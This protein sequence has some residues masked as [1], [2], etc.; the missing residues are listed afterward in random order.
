MKLSEQRRYF[1]VEA[2]ARVV[3]RALENAEIEAARARVRGALPP[4]ASS[5]A[6]DGA[7]SAGERAILAALEK[8]ATR[9]SRLERV[10]ETET[11]VAAPEPPA[12]AD[13]LPPTR[14]VISGSGFA[15]AF[16][17]ETQPGAL[18][19]ASIELVDAGVPPIAALA[20]VV[21]R[22][23]GDAPRERGFRFE[24]ISPDDRERIVQFALRTQSQALRRERGGESA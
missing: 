21:E 19:E 13:R 16:A 8:L 1:R 7:F 5:A 24:E 23:P 11:S 20:R 22:K 17:L 2:R 12:K 4:V 15:G 10:L 6:D 3:V 14:I 9:V 18:V